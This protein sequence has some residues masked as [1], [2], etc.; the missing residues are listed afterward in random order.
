MDF[1]KALLFQLATA[2]VCLA[3]AFLL[4]VGP[5]LWRGWG[6]ILIIPGIPVAALGFVMLS[7]LWGG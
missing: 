4:I 5:I 3:A 7:E 6:L 2:A 1:I